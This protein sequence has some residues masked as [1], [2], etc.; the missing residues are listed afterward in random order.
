MGTVPVSRHLHARPDTA[1]PDPS[2][3]GLDLPI[4]QGNPTE[5]HETAPRPKGRSAK[6]RAYRRTSGHGSRA[7]ERDSAPR[8]LWLRPPLPRKD[9]PVDPTIPLSSSRLRRLSAIDARGGML[10]VTLV[11][12]GP[13]LAGVLPF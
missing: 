11:F 1:V 12:R 5:P 13:S 9:G 7:T 6:P 4:S 2:T 10:P 3:A 8:S